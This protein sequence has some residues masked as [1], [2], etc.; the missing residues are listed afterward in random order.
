MTAVVLSAPFGLSVIS[1]TGT[2]PFLDSSLLRLVFSTAATYS[3]VTVNAYNRW[4]L[5]PVDG[6]STAQPTAPVD[7]RRARSPDA[8]IVGAIGPFP[9]G[10]RRAALLLGPA[11]VRGRA[12]LVARQARP[13]HDPRRRLASSRSPSSPCPTRVHERYLF[14]LFAPRRDPVRVLVALA[15]R[16]RRRGRGDVP[17]HVRRPRR[18][19]TRTTRSISRL[20]G[21]RRARSARRSASTLVAV[22]HT[23]GVP[24]GASPAAAG[25]ARRTLAAEL[26]EGRAAAAVEPSRRP[27]AAPR[28][29]RP[30]PAG[31]WPARRRRG[32]GPATALAAAVAGRRPRGSAA[33]PRPSAARGPGLVR[34]P[35][36]GRSWARSPG[37]A[38]GST[39][40]RSGPT[41][42]GC[43]DRERRRPPRPARPVDPR[44][45]RRR[46]AWAC[47]C[48]GS[49]S[50]PGCTSTRSTTPGPRPSS[51][52]T[53]ATASTHTSTSGRTRTSRS[54]RWPAG[55]SLFAG[56]DV[57]ATSDLGVPVRDAAI[58]PR[59]DGPDGGGDARRR[60]VWVATGDERRRAY[61][62]HTRKAVGT[63]ERAGRERRR[64]R[65]ATATS[66]T[67]A[68]TRA[69][70]WALDTTIAGRAATRAPIDAGHRRSRAPGRD[71]R[72]P[73]HAAGDVRRRHHVAAVLGDGHGRGRGPGHRRGA[74][75]ASRSPAPCDMT[76]AGT[77]R[78]RSSRR[79]ADDRRRRGPGRRARRDHRRRRRVLEAS[80]GDVDADTRGPRRR[81]ADRRHRAA[82]QTAIDGRPA[83]RGRRSR[84]CP[85]ARGRRRRRR[86]VPRPPRPASRGT[87]DARRRRARP[88]ARQRRRRTARSSTSPPSTRRATDA[89]GREV[90]AVTGD[91]AEGRPEAHRHVPAARSRHAGRVRRGVG[92]RRGPRRDGRTATGT[93]VYVLEPH[94]PPSVFADHQLPFAP[95]GLGARPQPRLPD[96]QPRRRSSPSAPTGEAAVA[97]R[98]PLHVRVAAAG[99]DPRR[100]HRRRPV[101]ARPGPVPRG[102]SVGDP[103]R[104]VRRCSTGCSS[105]RAGSR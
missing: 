36:A 73:D 87:V 4:A 16:L 83:D 24:V 61:D 98:R 93:T 50:P 28:P 56:H 52:R 12:G 55:S 26:E 76:A 20:A 27:C 11:A 45:A 19:S 80:L 37:C 70:C 25:G 23:G 1:L 40:R 69:S 64:L 54:T 105:S 8:T 78:R 68:P 14:P 39:R 71:A 84:P 47:A 17:E 13:A 81:V 7:P 90:V 63:L 92:A 42:R 100:A 95:V 57:A 62:L 35:G 18:R 104:A 79:P 6:Q 101:P 48:S 82:L 2:A 74:R 66:C 3:Y 43:C 103:R 21:D 75:R 77:R 34:P 88:R 44:R 30:R 102:A 46:G 97:R 5:F 58:E 99:R 72:R 65:R 22:L 60:R 38:R 67:S 32:A 49:P 33:R 53:G 10:A 85:A 51:C 86:D 15:G 9:A 89:R 59:R 29:R 96:R 91:D 94:G 31:A 41:A